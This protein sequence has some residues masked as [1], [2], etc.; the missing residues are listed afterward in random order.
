MRAFLS[1]KLNFK[2]YIADFLLQVK[3]YMG[4]DDDLKEDGVPPESDEQRKFGCSNF[5]KIIV[6]FQKW[7]VFASMPWKLQLA[8]EC[9][10]RK[11][12]KHGCYVSIAVECSDLEFGWNVGELVLRKLTHN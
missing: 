9:S 12:R 3:R 11:T 2:M 6:S 1:D 10:W 8:H 4:D 7:S 5:F